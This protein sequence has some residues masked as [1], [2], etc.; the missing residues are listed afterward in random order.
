MPIYE[1]RCESCGHEQEHLQKVNDAPITTCPTCGSGTYV[2][3]LSAAGFAF[4]GDGW[5]VTDYKGNSNT[6]KSTNATAD[7][8]GCG[9]GACEACAAT[10]E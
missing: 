5:Y 3:L 10:T 2:K 1:Y 8:S 9:A 6:K 7:N 4:K